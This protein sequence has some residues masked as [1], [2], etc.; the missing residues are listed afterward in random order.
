M[1]P[2]THLTSWIGYSAFLYQKKKSTAFRSFQECLG[3]LLSEGTGDTSSFC[4]EQHL[5][6]KLR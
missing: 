5:L 2:Q 4:Q 3:Q 6:D 1:Q